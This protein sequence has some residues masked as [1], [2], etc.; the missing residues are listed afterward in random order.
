MPVCRC[1]VG[2]CGI[3][4][5]T[6]DEFINK[7]FV[8]DLHF[9]PEIGI[10]GG[11]IKLLALAVLVRQNHPLTVFYGVTREN[12]G[13]TDERD[14]DREIVVAVYGGGAVARS[15]FKHHTLHTE[16]GRLGL[17]ENPCDKLFLTV[18]IH[19]PPVVILYRTAGLVVF[20]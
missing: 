4:L 13:S 9:E 16:I 10:F 6:V 19:I 3:A 11:V 8:S 1:A 17:V 7:V 12:G 20:H 14:N 5:I 2:A 15:K 18:A